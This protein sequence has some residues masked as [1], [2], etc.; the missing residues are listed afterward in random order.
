MIDKEVG[1]NLWHGNLNE[2]DIVQ[3]ITGNF[4]QNVASAWASY[5]FIEPKC[6]TQIFVAEFKYK[7]RWAT[8][9]YPR[10]YVLFYT[11]SKELV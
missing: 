4:W 1:E 3:K 10:Y 8:D 11:S 5:N 6:K 7:N 2:T 9:I